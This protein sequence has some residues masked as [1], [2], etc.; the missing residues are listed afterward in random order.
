MS[1]V[2]ES[3]AAFH[4]LSHQKQTQF[5]NILAEI[6]KEMESNQIAQD[7]NELE[8]QISVET[9]P[10]DAVDEILDLFDESVNAFLKL[11]ELLHVT[12]DEET[13]SELEHIRTKLQHRGVNTFLLTHGDFCPD[14]IF[15]TFSIDI[16]E[17]DKKH[18]KKVHVHSVKF[19]DFTKSAFRHPF[20]DVVYP[21]MLWPSCWCIK[22]LPSSV[23]KH[24][25]SNYL[26]AFIKHAL[27]QSAKETTD[28]V[29]LKRRWF[30]GNVI[31]F[32]TYHLL[33][34]TTF[35]MEDAWNSSPQK[36]YGTMTLREAI[37][38]RFEAYLRLFERGKDRSHNE[39]QQD[40]YKHLRHTVK[41]LL[42]RL[43][44]SWPE[45][46]KVK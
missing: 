20:F 45:S 39:Q 31:D 10:Y 37:I 32:S 11:C 12:A 23:V 5:A 4:L 27:R 30:L 24:F 14:N 22:R 38:Q 46:V 26:S 9:V 44:N 6:M 2:G 29:D 43:K 34:T 42:K 1:T 7:K 13:L 19:I 33:V 40:G 16:D 28:N 3:L 18:Q 21:R 41:E 35:N 8:E 25:E 15:I 17:N 36:T